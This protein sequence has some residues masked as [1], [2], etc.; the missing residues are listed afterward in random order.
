MNWTIEQIKSILAE[1]GLKIKT[2]ARTSNNHGTRIDLE[3]GAIINVFDTGKVSVQGKNADSIKPLF[4]NEELATA[5]L[6]NKVFVVYGHD[7]GSRNQ[8]ELFLRKTG[9]EPLILDQLP[10]GGTT[11]I[12]KLEHNIDEASLG[13]VLITPDDVGH[14]KDHPEEIM[15]RARQNVVL[16][17]GMLL[18]KLGRKKVFILV[19]EQESTEKPSD[20]A[21]LIY[22]AFK[23]DVKEIGPLFAK[24]V[25]QFGFNIPASALS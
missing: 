7:M 16:E 6:N 25:E 9:F 18:A 19:K 22:M 14:R 8:L 24:E 23:D 20:I 11:I 2:E 17:L 5:P 13:I 15:G 4:E 12:E 3:N 10:S 21:G 1:N